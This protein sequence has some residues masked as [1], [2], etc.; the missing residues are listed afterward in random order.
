MNANDRRI[1]QIELQKQGYAIRDIGQWPPKATYYKPNG[2]AMPN[3]PADPYSMKRYFRRG[4][5]LMPPAAP[6]G[7]DDGI[8]VCPQCGCEAKSDFGLQAHMRKHKLESKNY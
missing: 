4:F 1:L 6:S 3:L 5:T 2:E 7:G 8:L